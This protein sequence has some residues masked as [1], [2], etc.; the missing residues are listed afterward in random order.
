[1]NLL[2][3][4]EHIYCNC[5]GIIGAWDREHFVCERCSRPFDLYSL[6]YDYLKI[7]DK[8][9]WIFPVRYRKDTI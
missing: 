8:T 3:D 7:N 5:G 6:A 2:P 1:M 4:Y 9:G